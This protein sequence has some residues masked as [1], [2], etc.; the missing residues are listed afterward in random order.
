M[1]IKEKLG[2]TALGFSQPQIWQEMTTAIGEMQSLIWND[3]LIKDDN[4][5]AEGVR[6]LSR[7]IAGALPMT[8]DSSSPDYPQFL[9]FLSTRIHY[10]LPATDC[11]YVWAPVHGDNVYRIKGNKGT[12][13]LFDIETRQGHFAHVHDWLTIDR[14]ADFEIGEDNEIEIIL[15]REPQPGNW[16][17]LGEG[18]GNIIFRQYY[19]DWSTEHPA[20]VTIE[21]VGATYPPA[22]LSQQDI[23]ERCQLFIDWLK[24][25]PQR[26]AQ[27]YLSYHDAPEDKLI[28]D[29]ID[30]GWEDLRYGKGTYHCAPDEALIIEV[31]L[32][33][34]DYWSIQLCSHFWEARDY[35]LRQTSLNGHQAYIAKDRSFT[36]VI[37]HSDPGIA[38]WLDAGGHE[39][40]L[41]SIRYYKADGIPVPTIRRVKLSDLNKELT[42]KV[43]RI[44]LEDRQEVL[45]ARAKSVVRRNCE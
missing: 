24:Y 31:D 37:S 14:K 10:G 6:Y 1:N 23:A 17:K 42:E 25:L 41:I 18:H 21:R 19:Y 7:L 27:V 4:T 33:A 40:G 43:S 29:S 44:S 5:R 15:S 45:K 32:P 28:F 22:A 3:P 16:I 36:A 2:V 26:F 12:A 13:R 11:Y 30:F 34:T 8:M 38:N 9:H 39:R 35:H 20:E